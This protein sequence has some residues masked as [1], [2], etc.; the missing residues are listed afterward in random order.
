M[1]GRLRVATIGCGYFAQFHHAAWATEPRAALVAVVDADRD[2]AARMA[3]AH[4]VPHI[5]A[6]AAEM[7]AAE[8]PDLVDIITPPAT[9]RDLIELTA[10]AGIATIC[11]KAFCRSLAEAQDAAGRAEAAGIMLAVHENF[12]FS[13]WY[14]EI[15]RLLR[16]GGLG[17]LYQLTFRLRPGDGQGVSAYLDRQPY[18]Q[19][20]ERFLVHETAI[21]FIDVFRF[22]LGEPRSVYA[23]L[24][25][26]NPAIAGEDAGLL[27]FDHGDG[28]RAVF[29][30]NRLSDHVAQ[31][32]RLTMGEFVAEGEAGTL[33]LDGDGGLFF[34]PFGRNEERRHAY[35]RR[36]EG[37]AGGAVAALQRHVLDHL[38]DGAPLENAAADY[39]ASL[40]VEE[41]VY[42]SAAD[43]ARI[44]L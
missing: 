28:V 13:P 8:A 35:A 26:L 36:D 39:L 18:F 4:G 5:Y 29:D 6:D 37:F 43:G 32:R 40:R 19:T 41:A 38:V 1:A 12:R 34:R 15:H 7:I 31:N 24:R 10:A 9:H 44:S 17:R 22:L 42:R 20:M 23:D 16:A 33:R 27:V 3:A 11:Q 2:K 30:G 21:H 14:R 25:R